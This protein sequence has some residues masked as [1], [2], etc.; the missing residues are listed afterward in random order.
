[1]KKQKTHPILD[2]LSGIS[3]G[4]Q[5]L[6][7]VFF[8]ILLFFP[9]WHF[10]SP[11]VHTEVRTTSTASYEGLDPTSYSYWRERTE[12]DIASARELAKPSLPLNV[13]L[14][15]NLSATIRAADRLKDPAERALAISSIIYAQI[16][17]NVGTNLDEALFALGNSPAVR[18]LRMSLAPPLAFFYQSTDRPRAVSAIHN[19]L[20]L[21]KETTFNPEDA[22]QKNALVQILDA[23]TVLDL[24]RELDTALKHLLASANSI[25]NENRKNLLLAFIVEQQIRFQKYADA[26]AT[27]PQV[28]QPP[29][30]AK[31]Y[32]KLIESRAQ[33]G[34]FSRE[35]VMESASDATSAVF[36]NKIRNPDLVTQTL[37]RIFINIARIED[38]E[39]RQ[40]TLQQLL[41]SEM[42][43]HANLYDLVR[44]A[45]IETRSLSTPMKVQLLSLVDNPRSATLR[46]ARG[47]PPLFS[48]IEQ[49]NEEL[50]DEQFLEQ[51]RQLLTPQ[52]LSKNRMYQEDIRILTNTA[53]ELLNWGQKKEAVLLLNRATKR[54]KGLDI[55]NKQGVSRTALAAILVSAGEIEAAQD[56]LHEE[57]EILTFS[58]R[59]SQT[60]RDFSRIAEIQLRARLLEEAF[61]T[62]REMLPGPAKTSLLQS[63]VWE[64][65]KIGQFDNAKKSVAEM[66]NSPA[67]TALRHSLEATVQRLSKKLNENVYTY[68][69]LEEIL[70]SNGADKPQRL[71]DLVVT[72]IQEGLLVDAREAARSISDPAIRDRAMDL[73]VQEATAVFRSYFSKLPLH[74]QVRKNMF[75]FG[76]QTAKEIS[77]PQNQLLAMERIYSQMALTLEVGEVLPE[78]EEILT[79]W[80]SLSDTEDL[81]VKIDCGLR[82]FQNELRRHASEV[83]GRVSGNW[84]VVPETAPFPSAEQKQILVTVAALVPRLPSA[85]ARAVRSAQL[86]ALF[87]QICDSENG[88]RHVEDA[89]RACETAEQKD[90]AAGVCLSLAQTLHEA[91]EWEKAEEMFTRA[92]R[93]AE[94][95]LSEEGGK[96]I[97]RLLGRRMRDRILAEICRGQAEVGKIADAMQTATNIREKFFVDRLCKAIG[98][99]QI[100]Q[101]AY[102]EAE[103]TFKNI[104]DPS[105]KNSSLNDALFRIRWD[106]SVQ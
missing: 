14:G 85:E 52:P 2:I 91:E 48:E 55:E 20:A 84:Y 105:W 54:I 21:L 19:Y 63:L 104:K 77:S 35:S 93:E 42:M 30:L 25:V 4:Q 16:N 13:L 64:Q 17:Q 58:Q 38:Q 12:R 98:Y 32:Q 90:I 45:L 57:G 6:I 24:D 78:R 29:L 72:L 7:V 96:K 70:R 34:T 99:L 100:S 94:K 1:M 50:T 27:L 26:L 3:S 43:V 56:L 83:R 79:L 106:V 53:M 33:V 67:K 76:F 71:F 86:A 80:S 10:L 60:D 69:P 87:Y 95:I 82:M 101:G 81:T 66:Q 51:A 11:H 40:E 59:T 75:S 73:I 103:A 46:K 9:L 39:V 23:C 49:K 62:L 37:E 44:S 97:D 28:T 5:F 15:S 47:M 88:K 92:V 65:I 74:Q 61:Q 102:E 68:P 36:Q 18:P 31:C 22:D 41:E 8:L 89:L